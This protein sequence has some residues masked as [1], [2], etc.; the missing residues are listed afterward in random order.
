MYVYNCWI[1]LLGFVYEEAHHR[2]LSHFYFRYLSSYHPCPIILTSFLPSNL[3]RNRMGFSAARCVYLHDM[4]WDP[5]TPELPCPVNP[6]GS[7]D[8]GTVQ[9]AWKKKERSFVRDFGFWSLMNYAERQSLFGA[10][11]VL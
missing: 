8:R 3:H 7:V 5:P 2:M 9:G 4:C 6:A 10:V 11:I 1:M